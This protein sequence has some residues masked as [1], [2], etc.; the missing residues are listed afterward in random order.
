MMFPEAP[1]P[2]PPPVVE[3]DE[4]WPALFVVPPPPVQ[5]DGDVFP[6][7]LISGIPVGIARTE[8]D[9]MRSRI[10]VRNFILIESRLVNNVAEKVDRES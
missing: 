9:E 3:F 7:V 10:E 4:P 8:E 5:V 1:P 6:L 2:L